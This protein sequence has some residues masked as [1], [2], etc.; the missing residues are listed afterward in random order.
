MRACRWLRARRSSPW[1]KESV[2]FGR[3][4]H[5]ECETE[6]LRSV[7]SWGLSVLFHALFLLI[8][9]LIIQFGRDELRQT[10]IESSMVD[11]QLGDVTSLVTAN[12]AG[13]PFTLTDSPDPPSLGL[14]PA[15]PDSEARGSAGSRFAQPLCTRPGRADA[16]L[17]RQGRLDRHGAAPA[18][19]RSTVTAPF[20]GRQG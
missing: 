6:T 14:E 5:G 2:A 8:L 13:D 18:S 4:S 17:G 15:D 12:R 16:A 19:S 11:T 7:P 10:S 20:S 1:A 3:S 9:A